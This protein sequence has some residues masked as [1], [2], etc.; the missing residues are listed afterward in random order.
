MLT[1]VS[2][3]NIT[4]PFVWIE[5]FRRWKRSGW[6]KWVPKPTS[7]THTQYLDL[8]TFLYMHKNKWMRVEEARFQIQWIYILLNLGIRS[9][10]RIVTVAGGRRRRRQRL[11]IGRER[12]V[13][14]KDKREKQSQQSETERKSESGHVYRLGTLSHSFSLSLS[15]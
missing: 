5:I 7:S 10:K 3:I 14:S 11:S 4:P 6:D 12:N 13:K 9:G 1:A 8:W 15:L 2:I